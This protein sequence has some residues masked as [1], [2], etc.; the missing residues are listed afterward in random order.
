M[1]HHT[2]H[3][4]F[5]HLLPSHQRQ[6]AHVTLARV[7][8]GLHE[9]NIGEPPQAPDRFMI[10]PGYPY[11]PPMAQPGYPLS[12]PQQ[13]HQMSQSRTRVV[14]PPPLLLPA[15]PRHPPF[16][17]RPSLSLFTAPLPPPFLIS[18]STSPLP[19]CLPIRPSFRRERATHYYP[20]TPVPP[21]RPPALAGLYRP[22]PISSPSH[23]AVVHK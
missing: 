7:Q 2:A 10:V 22:H 5:E 18:L 11:R 19:L 20:L 21:T 16:P 13:S 8:H 17:L 1:T 14:Q 9:G 12:R 23:H 3:A 6:L 4:E 15:L